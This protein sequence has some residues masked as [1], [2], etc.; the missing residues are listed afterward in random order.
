[1]K[2]AET[3]LTPTIL[4]VLKQMSADWAAENS[5]RGYY[6]NDESDIRGNRI[7][8]AL[9]GDTPVGYL[10]GQ[11]TR[12]ERTSTVIEE[13]TPYFEVEELYIAPGWRSRGV[14]G[15]LFRYAESQVK[16]DAEYILLST[17]TK[18]W[19]AILHFYI[20]EM[21]MDFWSARLFKKIGESL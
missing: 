10:F 5:C 4:E 14:G 20:D 9:E 18:N 12:A 16:Q 17:A 19:K 8:L 11:V 21:G 7:F 2:Y 13:N 15:A 3:E 1:M 6:A